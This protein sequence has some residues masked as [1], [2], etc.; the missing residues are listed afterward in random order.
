M[1]NIL[2]RKKKKNKILYYDMRKKYLYM[3]EVEVS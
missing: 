1:I 2:K 3:Y